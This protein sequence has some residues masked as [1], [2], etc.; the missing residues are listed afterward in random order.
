MFSKLI[1]IIGPPCSGKS[2]IGKKLA[3]NLGYKYISS[4]DI[5]RDLANE[6]QTTK[7]N[8]G[9]MFDERTMRSSIYNE[10]TENL[11]NDI[12]V[13]LDGFPRNCGQY[14]WL[15]ENM[16]YAHPVFV[17]V[18]V[19][20]ATIMERVKKRNR[21]DD[22]SIAKRLEDYQHFTAPM[23]QMIARSDTNNMLIMEN[24]GI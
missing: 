20:M 6:E 8:N 24:N 18:K 19:S 15:G 17:L 9:E 4:G 14:E 12:G 5:A 3:E 13:V 23:V 16:S 2:T 7:L 11:T 22:K 10:V 1:V 21:D